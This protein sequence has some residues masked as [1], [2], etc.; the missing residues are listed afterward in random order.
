[1]ISAALLQ[2]LGNG[3]LEPDA[4]FRRDGV[5]LTLHAI[6]G[7]RAGDGRTTRVRRD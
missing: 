5:D 4:R 6:A 1:V 7:N 2:E 3:R